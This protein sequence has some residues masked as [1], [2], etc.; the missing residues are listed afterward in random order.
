[1]EASHDEEVHLHFLILFKIQMKIIEMI[2][3][4]RTVLKY[5][6]QNVTNNIHM[7]DQNR[8]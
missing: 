6:D 5:F 4:L 8:F 2:Q 7:Q 3:S 1:M